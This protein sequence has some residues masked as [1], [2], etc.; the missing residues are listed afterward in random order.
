MASVCSSYKASE[1][2]ISALL[3]QSTELLSS[4]LTCPVTPVATAQQQKGDSEDSA[5]LQDLDPGTLAGTYLLEPRGAPQGLCTVYGGPL[6]GE[7]APTL[8]PDARTLLLLLLVD[9]RDAGGLGKVDA[10]GL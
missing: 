8:F 6:K 3:K 4:L 9:A 2:D 7:L 5:H 1:A 10:A